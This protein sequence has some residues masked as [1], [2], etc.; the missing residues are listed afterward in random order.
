VKWLGHESNTY[1]AP[2]LEV[3]AMQ[4]SPPPLFLHDPQN[5]TQFVRTR[6]NCNM[7]AI[8]INYVKMRHM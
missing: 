5:F 3:H 8:E 6:V 2:R 7:S 4:L 1:P